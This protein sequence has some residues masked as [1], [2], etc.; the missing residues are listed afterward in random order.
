MRTT[1]VTAEMLLGYQ[2]TRYPEAEGT[3]YLHLVRGAAP[4]TVCLQ[5][6]A[7]INTVSGVNM[8]TRRQ[9]LKIKVILCKLNLQ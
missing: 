8:T 4:S 5:Q 1:L 6:S 7:A 3:C 9:L 2:C